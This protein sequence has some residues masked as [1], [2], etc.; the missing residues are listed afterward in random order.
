MC[1]MKYK[2]GSVTGLT[3]R[4]MLVVS[5]EDDETMIIDASGFPKM[6]CSS[7]N[8]PVEIAQGCK[9]NRYDVMGDDFV[10]DLDLDMQTMVMVKMA[11]ERHPMMLGK[12]S[13]HLVRVYR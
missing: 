11:A 5:V 2:K 6:T 9:K 4:G 12:L 7:C 8:E 10:V 1:D 13:E 3:E